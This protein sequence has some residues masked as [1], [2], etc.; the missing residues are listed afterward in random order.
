MKK[1]NDLANKD[2]ENS[3]CGKGEISSLWCVFTICCRTLRQCCFGSTSAAVVCYSTGLNQE[4]EPTHFLFRVFQE[5]THIQPPP[6][7]THIN[8]INRIAGMIGAGSSDYATVRDAISEMDTANHVA[9]RL[10]KRSSKHTP[11]SHPRSRCVPKVKNFS[12]TTTTTPLPGAYVGLR[13]RLPSYI[14]ECL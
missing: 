13:Q 7:H 6:S 4:T 11:R 8:K 3:L 9:G 2:T 14:N 5:N 12:P 1:Q 10:R